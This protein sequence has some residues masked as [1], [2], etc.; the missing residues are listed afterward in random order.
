MTPI[1]RALF[2]ASLVLIMSCRTA[3][4]P[5][6]C[7][8]FDEVLR[9]MQALQLA[10]DWTSLHR[11]EIQRSWGKPPL[12]QSNDRLAFE[13]SPSAQ[14]CGCFQVAHFRD[15]QLHSI[16]IARWDEDE[17]LATTHAHQ[18]AT[19]VRP[20]GAEEV[21]STSDG[22]FMYRWA[23]PDAGSEHRQLGLDLTVSPCAGGAYLRAVVTLFRTHGTHS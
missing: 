13:T 4:P 5:P 16:T 1:V 21:S 18:L 7:E 12:D 9:V 2:I 6:A 10:E 17:E 22:V 11:P 19:A 3:T 15:G 23:L 20:F 8:E 14:S